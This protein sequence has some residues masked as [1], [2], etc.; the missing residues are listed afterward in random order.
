M[1]NFALRIIIQNP[2]Y[3]RLS[4]RCGKA[5]L[6]SQCASVD[7]WLQLAKQALDEPSDH[8]YAEYLAVEAE[9]ECME[10]SEYVQSANFHAQIPG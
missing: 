10:P 9:K 7:D 8:P 1:N 6:E 5:S 3:F 2:T 4:I